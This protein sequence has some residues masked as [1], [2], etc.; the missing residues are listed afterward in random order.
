MKEAPKWP[1]ASED[2]NYTEEDLNYLL[3]SWTKGLEEERTLSEEIKKEQQ[4]EA[5]QARGY[6]MTRAAADNVPVNVKTA[7]AYK[8]YGKT[9]KRRLWSHWY[10]DLNI[11]RKNLRK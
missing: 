1:T 5:A 10:T 6:L 8:T 7:F 4:S 2:G 11:K 9:F 3:S